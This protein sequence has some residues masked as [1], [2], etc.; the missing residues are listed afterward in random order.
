MVPS[1]I[2]RAGLTF[3]HLHPLPDPSLGPPHGAEEMGMVMTVLDLWPLFVEATPGMA[4]LLS[5]GR[6]TK[7]YC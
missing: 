1:D 4:L 7:P 6:M 2:F 5:R 3:S